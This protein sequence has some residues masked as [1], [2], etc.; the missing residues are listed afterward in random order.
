MPLPVNHIV[1]HHRNLPK[2]LQVNQYIAQQGMI[3]SIPLVVQEVVTVAL[4]DMGT[5]E[6]GAVI[7]EVGAMATVDRV[8]EEDTAEEEDIRPIVVPVVHI[9]EVEVEDIRPIVVQVV[10]IVEV[11]IVE[12]VEAINTV[13]VMIAM[14]IRILDTSRQENRDHMDTHLQILSV[15]MKKKHCT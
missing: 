1:L 14:S 9:A 4:E 3:T 10:H 12:V 8:V 6:V 13:N 15:N 2:S 11:D 7:V 5:V